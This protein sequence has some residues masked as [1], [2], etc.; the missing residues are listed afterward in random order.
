VPVFSAGNTGPGDASSVSPANNPE[1]F[2]VGATD[3]ADQIWGESARGPSACG[4]SETDYPEMVTP[5][6]DIRTTDLYSTYQ[7][8]SGTSL[9]AP[10]SPGHWPCYGAHSPI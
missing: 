10:T 4:E 7:T 9:A 8:T 3:N 1:A 5:G 2:A 6:V